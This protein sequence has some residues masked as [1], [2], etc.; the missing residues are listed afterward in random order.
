[1]EMRVFLLTL[2][3]LLAFIR[4]YEGE[5]I[6]VSHFPKFPFVYVGDDI[7]LTCNG[8][9]EPIKW[10]FNDKLQ[11][12]HND[13]SMLL[14]ALT[15]EN[16]GRYHCERN[17][18]QSDPYQLTVLELE[19]H[20]QLSLS[21]GGAVVV[22]G[23]GR[24]LVL[25]VDNKL[26]GWKCFASRF[27]EGSSFK[28]SIDPD[29][30]MQR[31][32]VFAELKEAKRA[33]FW[34][35]NRN[36]THRSN[37]VTLKMTESKVMLEPPATPVM[38]GETVALRCVVWGG[39]KVEQAVFYQNGKKIDTINDDTYTITHTTQENNGQYSCHA[40]YRYSHISQQAAQQEGDSDPQELKVM[41]T[42]GPPVPSVS[43][44]SSNILQC[45]CPQCHANCTS[46]HW[47]H[48]PFY[49]SIIHTIQPKTSQNL[50]ITEEGLYSCRVN[51]GNGFSCFSKA[52]SHKVSAGGGGIIIALTA[53]LII[54]GV[55]IIVLVVLKRRKRGE[56]RKQA[57]GGG[58]DDR[59]KQSDGDYEQ[60]HL[61]D[62]A[63]YHTLSEVTGQDKVEG[64]YEPLKKQEDAVYHT[65]EPGEVQSQGQGEGQGQGQGQGQG[66]YEALKNVKAEVYHT[67]GPGEGE[68]QGQGEGTGKA[69]DYEVMLVEDNPYE[70]LKGE[71]QEKKQTSKKS[72]E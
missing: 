38:R 11:Q 19:P 62:Q 63:V 13:S 32:F 15:P 37:A 33:S 51:C 3:V 67:L 1:M 5:K 25:H 43:L 26:K 58:K 59:K 14:T 40:T 68:S 66:G 36:I 50:Y 12:S 65:L 35:L 42:G 16:N 61:T 31:G 17:G 2:S 41:V 30:E 7:S 48:T 45:N 21:T 69:A 72:K 27:G 49:D 18:V 70:E 60:I 23:D 52:Y 20:A 39:G 28:L 57:V 22:K 10:Y 47:Y 44:K 29:K 6:T 8:N 71:K 9:G 46:Y 53:F 54:L 4:E 34:C 64:G 56:S 24:T 55:L